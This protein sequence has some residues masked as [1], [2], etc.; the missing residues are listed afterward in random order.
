MSV[1][2]G[3]PLVH[4]HTTTPWQ[5][6]LLA[7][8]QSCAAHAVPIT[9]SATAPSPHH[10]SVNPAQS[11]PPRP[12]RGSTWPNAHHHRIAYRQRRSVV[13]TWNAHDG[14]PWT[15]QRRCRKGYRRRSAISTSS[16]GDLG[17]GAGRSWGRNQFYPPR[18]GTT[19]DEQE[20]D[21]QDSPH[22]QTVSFA[23]WW[24]CPGHWEDWWWRW[25]RCFWQN[26][27]SVFQGSYSGNT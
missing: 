22:D 27:T 7:S 3:T 18:P 8:Y 19:H 1:F 13:S 4:P 5:R 23:S 9:R 21:R 6:V 2:Y 17:V 15:I 16:E 24:W 20:Y 10:L 14:R 25:P 11:A 12:R 26:R